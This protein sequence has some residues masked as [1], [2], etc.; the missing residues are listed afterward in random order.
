MPESE[1]DLSAWQCY[2][3]NRKAVYAA[4]GVEMTEVSAAIIERD[5]KFL[6]CRRPA[7]KSRP[8]MWE[9]A[10]GKREQGETGE[11]ALERECAEELGVKIKAGE[12]FA[13]SVYSYEDIDV[14]ITFYRAEIVSGEPRRLEHAELRWV[15]PSEMKN[16]DFCPADESVTQLLAEEEGE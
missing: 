13:R 15:S 8:M 10:G 14:S 1:V 5:G 6:V 7:H 16:L 9:F 3:S 11:Q 2:N 12:A 4:A